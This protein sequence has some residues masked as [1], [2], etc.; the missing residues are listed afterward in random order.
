MTGGKGKTALVTGASSGIG[1]VCRV[2]AEKG[3]A[4][5]LTARRRDRLDA[6]AASCAAQHGVEAHDRC[7]SGASPMRR[8]R[9][10]PSCDRA[11]S[12]IDLLV[13]NAGYGVPGSYVNV[14]WPSTSAFM[15]VM[16]TAVLELTYRLLPGMIER[17]WGRIINIASVAGMM[18]A[19]AGHTLYGASKAFLIRF[20]KRSPPRT[21]RRASTSPRCARDSPERVPRRDRHARQD[22]QDARPALAQGRPTWREKATTPSCAGRSGVVNGRI[23]QLRSGVVERRAAAHSLARCAWRAPSPDGAI[24][25]PELRPAGIVESGMAE[26]LLKD[27][28]YACAGWRRSPGFPPSPSC[29][30]VS[31][32]ASTPRC[33]RW[34]TRCCSGR[35]RSTSPGT[36]VDVFTTGG[37][38]DEYATSS[39]PDF[40]DLK[41]Q[42]TV[43]S[44]MTRL[45]PD[46]GAAQPGRSVAARHGPGRDLESLSR[47]SASSRARAGCSCRGRRPWRAERVVVIAH[48]MWQREFGGA[49]RPLSA[50]ADVARPAIHDRRRRAGGISLA[51]SRC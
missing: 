37:D 48:R 50:D 20:R 14:P 1:G 51:S 15:Q 22:E 38:G 28:R 6:L 21:R 5:V 43:F 36:L 9:L 10:P 7:R 13:N 2:L 3:Y 44:D 30:S 29:R 32:S 27:I 42:N 11:S 19:P 41:A 49:I 35:C 39:Y 47:C 8:R 31:A 33:S 4:L 26:T 12:T 18:P 24:A 17:G 25:R 45:Q 34:S 16:V 46:D 40:L 23:Y